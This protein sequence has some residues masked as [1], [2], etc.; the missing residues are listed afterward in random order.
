MKT[1]YPQNALENRENP[2]TARIL[3]ILILATVI[4][5]LT[6]FLVALYWGDW[7]VTLVAG[8]GIVVQMVPYWL[9][10]RR[11][12]LTSSLVTTMSTLIIVTF[13]ATFGQGI[14]DVAVVVYPVIFVFAG[15]TLSRAYFGICVGMTLVA[16]L[17][18]ALGEAN[19]WFVTRPFFEDPSNRFYL[20]DVTVILLVAAVAVDLLA[21]NMRRSLKQAR[22]E[23]TQRQRAEEKLTQ[24]YIEE[25]KLRQ[26]LEE[27]A[28]NRIRFVDVLA[29]EL[30]GPLTPMLAA[31]GILKDLLGANPE[32]VQKKLA[33]NIFMGTQLLT[34][35]L[36]ELLD[37][38]RYSRGTITLNREPT[39]V[40]KFIEQT[41]SRFQ[42]SI[43]QRTQELTV[44]RAEDLPAANLDQS[45]IEQVIINLLSNASKYSPE[46]SHIWLSANQV[47]NE[48]LIEVKDEGIGIS[49]EDQA[50][51]F[52]PYQRVG[53][54]QQKIKGL[55]LGLMVVKSIVVAHSGKVWVTSELGKGSTFSFSIPIK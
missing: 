8:V 29:H 46:G 52:Q 5:L 55:G 48:I 18:L 31:S 45:R 1:M 9:L 20:I 49:P 2:Q 41:V 27:E 53:H 39:D 47:E 28:E 4:A 35:R 12:L 7:T 43:T 50:S 51:L 42:P 10:R 15:L 37:V 17:W 38:A 22:E 44:E 19:S 40:R 54:D 25:K 16:I 24:S 23:I 32:S 26:Q 21:T 11:H 30:K 36:E 14:Y 6:A 34:S 3:L 13:I 33:D